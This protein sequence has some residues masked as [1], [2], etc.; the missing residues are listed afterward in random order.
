MAT[1]ASIIEQ[2]NSQGVPESVARNPAAQFGRGTRVYK[3][4]T[5][6]PERL[7]PDNTYREQSIRFRTVIAPD[8]TRY[9]AVQKRGSDL[10]ASFLV[11]LGHSDI[12]VPMNSQDYDSLRSYLQVNQDMAA[13]AVMTRW[14]DVH[15]N[16]ALL[17]NME[18]QRWE[19]IVDSA[20]RRVGDNNYEE[21]VSF[22]NP[23]GHRA[24]Q[25][26]PWSTNTTD[27]FDNI[28]TMAQVMTDK[29]FRVGR[30]IT[31]Q[32]VLSKMTRNST[33]K[34]RGGVAVVNSTGQITSAG[35]RMTLQGINDVMQSDGLPPIETY[36]LQYQTQTGSQRFLKNDVM[37]L[38]ATTDRGGELDLA[39]NTDQFPMSFGSVLGY[40]A[41]GR[42][43]GQSM[44]GR[45][46]RMEVFEN[47]P[48]RIDSEGWMTHL[49]IIQEPEAIAVITGIT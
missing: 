5:I 45:V 49:P 3:G 29:G 8:G 19:A 38:L 34:T 10:F 27:I 46:I 6:L 11:E 47:K 44:P 42:A 16:T 17:E 7:V 43:A 21:V 23:A 13:M 18:R 25:S 31:S 14:L 35:G 33:V 32:N 36:D 22:A 1:L 12:G 40:H 48:P 4:A 15:I 39:D 28:Q 20:V 9:S 37:V 2:M 24:A 30:I 26:A 41:V